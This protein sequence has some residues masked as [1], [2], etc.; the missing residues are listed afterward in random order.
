MT[1]DKIRD[2]LIEYNRQFKKNSGHFKSFEVIFDY[3]NFLRSEPFLKK[4]L[5]FAFKYTD[6]QIELIFETAR[7]P[8]KSKKFDNLNLDILNPSTL[9][10][11][12]ILTKEFKTWQ[13][14]LENKEDIPFA[15]SLF[16][17]NLITLALVAELMQEIKDCQKAGDYERVRELTKT[18]EEES[19]SIMPAHNVKNIPPFVATSNQF[20]DSSMELVNKFIIDKIDAQA[21]LENQKP[22][23]AV[24]FDKEKSIL[25]IRGQKIKITLK[26]DKPID[27]Y[28]LEC[29]FS[30]DDLFEQTDFVEIAENFLNEDYNGN[31]QR[32]RHSCEKLN[33]K[34]AKATDYKI[35]DFIE[36]TTGKTGWCKIN[37]KYL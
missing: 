1:I 25:Y 3:I 12:P 34:I 7:S 26:N 29:I 17:T 28:I 31:W 6:E 24:D 19:F 30:K 27:H 15:S 2:Q 32:F 16:S 35:N 5:I 4:L 8:E 20:L 22:K 36:S 13:K 23:P 18:V 10:E 21:F 14:A 11:V 37:Q 33:K 9:S